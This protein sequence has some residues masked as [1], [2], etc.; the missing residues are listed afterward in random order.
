[1]HQH[2]TKESERLIV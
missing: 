2:H 1:M